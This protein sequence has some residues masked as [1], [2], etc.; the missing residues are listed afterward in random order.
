M[1]KIEQMIMDLPACR[2]AGALTKMVW[3][4]NPDDMPDY[5]DGIWY[6]Y[7]LE[8]DDNSLY[9]GFT[10]NLKQRYLQHL[11][12]IGAKHTKLHKP[13][14]LLYYEVYYSEKEAV[15]KEKYLKS[16]IGREFL[17]KIQKKYE[18]K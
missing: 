13:V 5:Q 3:C 4:N 16:G 17:K 12:G 6:V 2:Q 11:N 15:D 1:N 8:C 14:C 9:K 10:T 18:N 7:V